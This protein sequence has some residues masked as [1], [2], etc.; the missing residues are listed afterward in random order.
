MKLASLKLQDAGA[1]VVASGE[2]P[3]PELTAAKALI[4]EAKSTLDKFDG[5][6]NRITAADLQ[7]IQSKVDQ[8]KA[9][10][11]EAGGSQDIE[12]RIAA[13]EEALAGAMTATKTAD[14]ANL[15]AGAAASASDGARRL[16]K[17]VSSKGAGGRDL[18][19][20]TSNVSEAE[21]AL[22]TVA[23]NEV[24]GNGANDDELKAANTTVDSALK[25]LD[26]EIK[27]ADGE[28][29]TELKEVKATLEKAAVSLEKRASFK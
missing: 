13:A 26:E 17:A 12:E 3:A 8:A 4:E 20:V 24:Y 6:A 15:V 16:E 21:K 28:L 25:A 18:T 5:E 7:A 22:G 1:K 10:V 2:E 29:A 19:K 23:L 11:I 27:G 14:M 9:L